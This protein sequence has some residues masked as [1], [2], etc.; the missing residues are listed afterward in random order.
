MTSPH[1]EDQFRQA[2]AE[3]VRAARNNGV[4]VE[5]GWDCPADGDAPEFGVEI[6]RVQRSPADGRSLPPD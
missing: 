2:L 5:G 1:T 6:Y 4:D 3:L